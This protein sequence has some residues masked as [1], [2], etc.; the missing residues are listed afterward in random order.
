MYA[1]QLDLEPMALSETG[2]DGGWVE[3]RPTQRQKPGGGDIF[4]MKKI[5]SAGQKGEVGSLHYRHNWQKGPK[6]FYPPPRIQPEGACGQVLSLAR[7]LHVHANT[8]TNQVVRSSAC[9]WRTV[10]SNAQDRQIQV[11]DRFGSSFQRTTIPSTIQYVQ[12]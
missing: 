2:T 5:D 1:R 12:S 11:P 8:S 9:Q 7:T 4:A 10:P 3:E 6:P